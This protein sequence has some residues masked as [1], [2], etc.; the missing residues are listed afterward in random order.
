MQLVSATLPQ[1]QPPPV[2]PGCL[3]LTHT[4]IHTSQSKV[5]HGPEVLV[6][7][8][9]VITLSELPCSPSNLTPEGW[10]LLL[11]TH[12]GGTGTEWDTGHETRCWEDMTCGHDL[13]LFQMGANHIPF[14]SVIIEPSC[15]GERERE[16]ATSQGEWM[17]RRFYNFP[18]APGQRG[19]QG[20]CWWHV[21]VMPTMRSA[22]IRRIWGS[23]S[24]WA[25]QMA[26][27]HLNCHP[28]EIRSISRRITVQTA[29][30]KSETSS[31]K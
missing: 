11:L 25:K 3:P 30:A 2:L 18:R 21:P 5:V 29:W 22:E 23:R 15:W 7:K 12:S 24:A 17:A 31:S 26:R 13:V 28:S 8:V 4:H 16:K 1:G 6:W 19:R 10:G 20:R 27:P 9:L 14:I